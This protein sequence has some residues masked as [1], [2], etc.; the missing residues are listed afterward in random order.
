MR[1]SHFAYFFLILT[2]LLVTST[3]YGQDTTITWMDGLWEETTEEKA[4]FYR[5]EWKENDLC[6]VH[7]FYLSGQIQMLGSYLTAEKKMKEGK[8][9][10]FS[11]EG[12][13]TS[14]GS[15]NRGLKVGA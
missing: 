10:Y 5:K 6:M 7:D 14:E 1:P 15:Y 11:P 12:A 9:I 8:F 2:S 3:I 4:E 13:K